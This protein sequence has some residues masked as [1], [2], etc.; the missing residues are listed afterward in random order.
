MTSLSRIAHQDQAVKSYHRAVIA[1]ELVFP[2]G[3]IPTDHSGN[4]PDTIQEQTA[5]ALD[6]LE[7]VLRSSGSSLGSIVQVTVY[8]SSKEDFEDYDAAWRQRFSGHPLPPRTSVF[9]AGFRGTKRI[10]ITAIAARE[11]GDKS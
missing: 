1:G 9:V 6:N 7:D 10:E 4:T 8:L 5:V 11:Q 3:Q 2:C